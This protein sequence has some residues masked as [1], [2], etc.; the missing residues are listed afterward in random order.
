MQNY[1]CAKNAES[2][3]RVKLLNRNGL[4]LCTVIFVIHNSTVRKADG[5]NPYEE[6]IQKIEH[7]K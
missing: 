4:T 7:G 1:G 3:R 2:M 6:D 5:K